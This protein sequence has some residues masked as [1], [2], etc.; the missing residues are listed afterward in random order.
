M[1]SVLQLFRLCLQFVKEKSYRVHELAALPKEEKR[2]ESENSLFL[3]YLTKENSSPGKDFIH[4]LDD[5]KGERR[6]G[7]AGS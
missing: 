6:A 7:Q 1:S 4:L 3:S 5:W 2:N